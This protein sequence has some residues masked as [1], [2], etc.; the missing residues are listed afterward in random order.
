MK[1]ELFKKIFN[2]GDKKDL[3]SNTNIFNWNKIYKEV[4]SNEKLMN[5][6]YEEIVSVHAKSL[7]ELCKLPEFLQENKDKYIVFITKNDD[8]IYLSDDE[9]VMIYVDGDENIN[10]EV[11]HSLKSPPYEFTI[12]ARELEGYSYDFGMIQITDKA[13]LWNKEQKTMCHNFNK[14]DTLNLEP[15]NFKSYVID[16]NF[17]LQDFF[18]INKDSYIVFLSNEEKDSIFHKKINH[19]YGFFDETEKYAG[20][21]YIRVFID[22]YEPWIKKEKQETKLFNLNLPISLKE[23]IESKAYEKSTT[24]SQYLIDL[25][26]KDMQP[27]NININLSLNSRDIKRLLVEGD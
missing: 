15:A 18:N 12:A 9:F 26:V 22:K 2:L 10:D 5:T 6:S 14:Y 11:P 17:T 27:K 23:Y 3:F 7:I 4:I 20:E 25:I 19:L 24:M 16:D 1:I 13:F 8:E 21:K